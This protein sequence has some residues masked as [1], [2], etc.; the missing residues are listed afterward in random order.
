MKKKSLAFLLILLFSISSLCSFVLAADTSALDQ[1]IKLISGFISTIYDG[2]IQPLAQFLIGKTASA[3]ADTF[4]TLIVMFILII[5]VV[6]VIVERIPTIGD[7]SWVCF[8]ISLLVSVISIR[9]IASQ[10]TWFQ[11]VLFPNQ[12]LGIALICLLPLVIY[13]FF[14]YDVAANN[15]TLRKIMWV[16][17]AVVF[18]SLYFLRYTELSGG[19]EGYSPAYIYLIT[20]L[21]CL[22]LLV[23]DGTVATAWYKSRLGAIQARSKNAHLIEVEFQIRRLLEIYTSGAITEAQYRQRKKEL[24]KTRDVLLKK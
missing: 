17:A 3:N 16:F 9:F 4:F 20:S 19:A 15:P 21:A 2:A 13:F 24:E 6:W 1:P 14:V 22:G 18:M 7:N 23:F 11:F 10:D 8:I 12:V 5:S